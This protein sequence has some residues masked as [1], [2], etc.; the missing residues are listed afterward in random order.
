L[1][2][3]FLREGPELAR[4]CDLINRA[5]AAGEVGLWRPGTDRIWLSELA[6]IARRG[7]LAV[8]RD[9]AGRILGSIRTSTGTLGLL[10]VEPDVQGAGTGRALVAFA[11]HES[12]ARGATTMHLQLLVPIDGEHPFKRRLHDWYSRLGYEV[13]GR[14]A[15][16]LAEP[17]AAEHLIVECDLVDYE[18]PL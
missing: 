15:F 4:V 17:A 7:E 11:E 3:E 1:R 5:Y 2:A 12:A 18:K 13:V 8:V 14:K 16:A 10:A 6:P 9:A